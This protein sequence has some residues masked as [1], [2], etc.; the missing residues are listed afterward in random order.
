[1]EDLI[2]TWKKGREAL[3]AGAVPGE[4]LALA[5]KK[6]RTVVYAQYGNVFVLVLSLV[7]LALFFR[8][9]APFRDLLSHIGMALMLGGLALRIAIEVAS[10]YKSRGIRFSGTADA[11]TN[12]GVS[13]YAFRKKV[14]GPV[15]MAIVGIYAIGFYLL[16][17][18]FSRYISLHWM[19]LMHL[20]FLSGGLFLIWVIR[21]G[22]KKEMTGLQHLAAIRTELSAGPEDG[23]A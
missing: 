17:P 21:K 7:G 3:N 19:V 20:S 10:I 2:N 13:Y 5:R 1:M 12:A 18:E 22:I 11:A 16:T 14:H 15:T 9:E 8:Y 4:M 6:K 23:Q